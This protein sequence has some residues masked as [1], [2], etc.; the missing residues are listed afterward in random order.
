M[1]EAALPGPL[2]MSRLS[3][4]EEQSPGAAWQAWEWG[5]ARTM[6]V[7]PRMLSQPVSIAL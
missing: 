7:L 5:L 2:P 4:G 3:S 6:W 1:A